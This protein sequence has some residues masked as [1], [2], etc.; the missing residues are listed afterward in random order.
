MS[1]IL[2]NISS[3]FGYEYFTTLTHPVLDCSSIKYMYQSPI[4]RHHPPIYPHKTLTHI[5]VFFVVFFYAG[6][7]VFLETGL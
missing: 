1:S 3:L 5:F 2:G 4:I 7:G 6:Y